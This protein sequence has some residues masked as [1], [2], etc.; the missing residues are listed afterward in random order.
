MATQVFIVLPDDST[1]VSCPSQP[2]ATL[3][4]YLLDNNGTLPVVSNVEYH[5]LPG[6]HH[7]HITMKLEYL[8]NVSFVGIES[9]VSSPVILVSCFNN[10][11][12]HILIKRSQ[13]VTI[14]KITF[15][16]YKVATNVTYLLLNICTYCRLEHVRFLEGGLITRNTFANFSINNVNIEHRQVL[17]ANNHINFAIKMIYDDE[18]WDSE[19]QMNMVEIRDILITGMA[20]IIISDSL[21]KMKHDVNVAV[22]NSLFYKM[23]SKVLAISSGV[24][25]PIQIKNCTFILN[26]CVYTEPMITIIMKRVYKKYIIFL[27]CKFYQNDYWSFLVLIHSLQAHSEIASCTT[28]PNVILQGCEFTNNRSPIMIIAGTISNSSCMLNVVIRG[29]SL[30]NNNLVPVASNPI[31]TASTVAVKLVGLVIV[32]NNFATNIIYCHYC[33]LVFTKYITFIS[34]HCNNLINLQSEMR[35]IKLLQYVNI[36]FSRNTYS[37]KLIVLQPAYSGNPYMFCGFQ[38]MTL[39][40]ISAT[41][42]SHYNITF[43]NNYYQDSGLRPA[44]QCDSIFYHFSS[45]C[46]WIPSSV[47]YG[48]N[49]V[50]INQQIIQTDQHQLNQH[51]FICHCSRNI[52]NCSVDVLG[53]VY[54]GQ[55]LQVELVYQMVIKTPFCM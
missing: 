49:P 39:K 20:R 55:V 17:M 13:N 3:S 37:N 22:C 4:Q 43:T 1:N 47:F 38:Y 11:Y 21:G 54:P 23:P 31:I 30:V 26:Q 5:F 28:A 18:L 15:R 35:Y 27:H 25:S 16:H 46:R 53:T 50:V 24:V 34:N 14:G 9:D 40:N 51:T 29:P 19:Y 41:L 42:I 8:S 33:S 10:P 6:E 44:Y 12:F 7:L 2:C 32:S 48:H 36:V 45:H 52:T